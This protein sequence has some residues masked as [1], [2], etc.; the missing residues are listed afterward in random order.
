MSLR[1]IFS[2][3]LLVLAGCAQAVD[4]S[5]WNISNYGSPTIQRQ[6]DGSTEIIGNAGSAGAYFKRADLERDKVYNSRLP[7]PNVPVASCFG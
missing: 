1:H 2:C 6:D 4:D 5:G 3:S 7:G